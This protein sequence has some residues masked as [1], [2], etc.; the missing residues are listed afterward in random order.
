MALRTAF[1]LAAVTLLISGCAGSPVYAPVFTGAPALGW[2]NAK[3]HRKH[4]QT[5]YVAGIYTSS[6]VLYGYSFP[7]L[8]LTYSTT[9]DFNEP[10][11][12]TADSSGA[13]YVANTYG[14]N[15][16]KFV[17]PATDPVLRFDDRGFRPTDVAVDF[18]GDIWVANW[19]TKKVTCGPGNV[20]E[21]S[22]T[23]TL[24]HTIRCSNLV[25]YTFLAIDGQDDVVVD[26]DAPY[27]TYSTAGEIAAGSTRC[28]TLTSIHTGA[29][30]G[31]QFLKN[32]D[33]TVIDTIDVVMRTYAKPSFTS[34]IATTHFY[35]VP[36]PVEDAFVR[37]DQYVW[38]SVQGYN[39]VFE[40]SYPNGGNPV[41]NI[42]GI[43]FPTG[44]AVTTSK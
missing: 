27:G 12:V 25:N 15:I 29:P 11:G 2:T 20:R 32:G 33:L 38:T 26:G 8:R 5:I 1:A 13:V 3:P 39:G 7:D 10:E 37:G 21:Y 28:R 30:G 16:L 6:G 4:R 31:V 40:F 17:P 23:G 44:V 24:L 19:C 36:T 9:T 18:K 35:D 43:Y 41:N 14:Y 34:V 42:G 22:A